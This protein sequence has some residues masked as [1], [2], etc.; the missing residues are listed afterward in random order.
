[1]DQGVGL[2]DGYIPGPMRITCPGTHLV[3]ADIPGCIWLLGLVFVA[4]GTFVLTVPLFAPEWSTFGP[5]E[6]AAVL[7]IGVSHLGGGL[8][9]IRHHAATRTELDRARGTGTHCLR[10]PGERAA[11][12]TGFR[13]AEVRDVDVSEEKDSDGDPVYALRL[14]LS[15]GRAL[16][17]QGHPAPGATSARERAAAIRQFL[18]LPAIPSVPRDG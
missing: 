16:R 3:A 6:R 10:R 2:R 1:M 17:L 18:R 9:T 12:V 7:A 5:W 13:L 15:D 11:T 8:W 14:L 4:S